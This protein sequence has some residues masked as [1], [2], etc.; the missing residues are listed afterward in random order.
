MSYE[1]YCRKYNES[2]RH[3][4][5]IEGQVFA[6]SATGPRHATTVG[7]LRRIIEGQLT[8]D[9]HI[10]EEKPIA[11]SGDSAPEPDLV[12]V[13]GTEDLYESSHPSAADVLLAIEIS[14]TTLAYD[15]NTK[16]PLYAGHGIVEVWI[17]SLG[18]QFVE[19]NRNPDS[20]SEPITIGT[21]AYRE[22]CSPVVW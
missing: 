5:L 11:L 18:E 2:G 8:G 15:R 10:R 13:N 1:A 16:L 3:V 19:I 7:R 12:V 21:S 9:L 14:D 20:S 17:V 22:S 6:M 4:E